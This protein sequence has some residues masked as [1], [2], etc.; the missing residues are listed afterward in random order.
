MSNINNLD[1]STARTTVESKT[2]DH[3]KHITIPEFYK[4][5]AEIFA[6]KLTQANLATK[7]DIAISVKKTDYDDKQKNLLQLK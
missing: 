3:S 1:T 6:A 4:L 7:K 2:P 5:A